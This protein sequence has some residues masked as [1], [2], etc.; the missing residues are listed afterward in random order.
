MGRNKMLTDDQK[1]VLEEIK[2]RAWS[3]GKNLSGKEI[4]E[5]LTQ[6]LVQQLLKSEMKVNN[7]SMSYAEA[8]G[9][10]LERFSPSAIIAYNV[11]LNKEL[12]ARRND[13]LWSIGT[14]LKTEIPTS[15]IGMLLGYWRKLTDNKTGGGDISKRLT[16]RRVRWMARLFPYFE[17]VWESKYLQEYEGKKSGT[18][19]YEDIKIGTLSRLADIYAER[20][21]IT[22]ET[23][24]P[25]DTRDLDTK[26]FV[27]GDLTLKYVLSPDFERQLKDLK[28]TPT[29]ENL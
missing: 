5:Q 20:Q 6:V 18:P 14:L 12:K 3:Q 26:F 9:I 7:K 17:D 23:G 24:E 16:I 29:W 25:F 28:N 22:K 15:M 8:E 13:P 10:V 11:I 21:E 1:R 2:E 19:E 4:I 27:K